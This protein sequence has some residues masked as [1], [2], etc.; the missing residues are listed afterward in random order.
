MLHQ[1]LTTEINGVHITVYETMHSGFYTQY[2][3]EQKQHDTIEKALKDFYS[4]IEHALVCD[5]TLEV[6]EE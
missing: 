6:E 2:G 4:C 5:G 3:L 1:I